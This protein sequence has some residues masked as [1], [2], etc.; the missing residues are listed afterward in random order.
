MAKKKTKGG[1]GGSRRGY[2]RR[3]LDERI[4]ALESRVAELKGQVKAKSRFSPDGVRAERER[5]DLTAAE[6]AELVG[7]SMITIYSWEHGRSRPRAE[8]LALWLAVQGISKEAAWKKL[9]IQELS[10]GGFSP[11]VIRAE[12]DRLELSAAR[13][14]QLM[15]VSMLTVYNWEKGKSFP[16]EPQLEKWLQVKGI[17]KREAWKRLG[18][19]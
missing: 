15:G 6:Y 4:A 8:Q 17:G 12:R 1:S 3:T 18:L 11:G 9:G 13:Y 16:R 19:E 5:L 7:V 14:G 10:T 2:T